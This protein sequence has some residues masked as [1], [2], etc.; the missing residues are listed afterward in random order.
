MSAG[1]DRWWLRAAELSEQAALS[2]TRSLHRAAYRLGDAI[3]QLEAD[4]PS[5]P[6]AVRQ[7][8]SECAVDADSGARRRGVGCVLRS[9]DGSGITVARLEGVEDLDLATLASPL[10]QPQPD[11]YYSIA[12]SPTPGWRVFRAHAQDAVPVLAVGDGCVVADESRLPPFFFRDYVVAA[13]LSVQR[14]VLF[15]HAASVSMGGSGVLLSGRAGGGKTTLSLALAARGHGFLGDDMAAIR[16]ES[17]ELLPLRRTVHIRSGL[18]DGLVDHAIRN[19]AVEQELR[20]DGARRLCAEPRGLFPDAPSDPVLLGGAFFLR[21][22]S[23]T[24]SLEPFTPS[25]KEMP[26][27]KTLP[28]R[29]SWGISPGGRLIRFLTIIRLLSRVRCWHLDVGRPAE[30]ARLI[31]TTL[32][33]S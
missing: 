22:F 19:G 3:L 6:D 1:L 2:P 7:L 14:S 32:E 27:L 26:A 12:A 24:P 16:M 13:T 17:R 28:I 29:W 23:K 33:D 9:L 18:R 15:L 8:Y 11:K 31:E 25:L 4:Q 10:L 21:R 20:P 5:V 30:T